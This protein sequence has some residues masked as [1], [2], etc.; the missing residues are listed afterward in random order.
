M[1]PSGTEI[2]ARP[3]ASAVDFSKACQKS[4]SVKMKRYASSPA[5]ASGMKNGADR[6]LW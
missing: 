3:K 6:K 2:T 4:E 5:S 1:P